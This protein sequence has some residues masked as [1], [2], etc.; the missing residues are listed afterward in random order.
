VQARRA[1]AFA[2]SAVV[3]IAFLPGLALGQAH[4]G[5]NKVHYQTFDWHVYRSPHFDVYY[6]P[7]G[8]PFLEQVVS[9]AESAYLYLS[10]ALD[11]EPK[12]R[13][14]LI[15]YRTHAEFEQTN[16]LLSSIPEGYLAFAEPLEH[17]VALSI[18]HPPD[19]V[20]KLIVHEL[21]HIFEFSILFQDSLGRAMRG[22]PPGWLME[23]LASYLAKD[24]N[25]I[26]QLVIRDA[27]IN[28][29]VPPIT[30]VT[31]VSFLTYRYGHAAFDF[32]ES[33]WG[34]EGLRTFIS[35]YRRVLLSSNI[36]KSIKEAFG[37][38]AEE[39][40]RLFKRYL[41]KKY[42]PTLLEKGEPE[43]Y[44]KEIGIK[45]P[46]VATVSPVLSPSG[47]LVAVLTNRYK[48]LD[49]VVLSTKDGEVIKNLTRGFTNSYEYVSS[50]AFR[51]MADLTWSPDGDRVAAFVRKENRRL[52]LIA[53]ALTGRKVALVEVNAANAASPAFSPDGRTILFSG[54][55]DGV[56]DIFELDLETGESRNITNDEYHDSNP[57]WSADGMTILYNRRVDAYAKIFLLDYEDPSRKTQV[58]F[59][60]TS[61]ITPSFSRDG[62]RI[63]YCSDAGEEGIFNIYSLDLDSG[64][65][66]KYT[67]VAGG[68]FQPQD[69]P[70]QEGKDTV[71]AT[72]FSKGR[73]RLFE[74]D[75]TKPLEVISP[76]ERA[77]QIADLEPFAAPLRLTV[78][79]QEKAPL[80]KRTY[81]IE[82]VPQVGVGVANDGTIYG[83]AFLLFSDLLGD[84]RFWV[85]ITSVANFQNFDIGYINLE[86]RLHYNFRIIDYRDFVLYG[87]ATGEYARVRANRITGGSAG[88]SYPL[89]KNYRVESSLGVYGREILDTGLETID[90]P[91]T[92][93]TAD[94]GFLTNSS[95]K[96]TVAI[97]SGSL[98]GDTV[99]Y[100]P[101]GPWHGKRF[102]FTASGA[103]FTSGD[104]EANFVNYSL[105][106]R[107]Y[108]KVTARSLF[109][110]RLSSFVSTGPG[111]RL[112]GIGGINQ[113]RGYEFREFIGD[114]AAWMNL[115]FR[116]PLVDELRLPF[117]SMRWF[118]GMVF[119]DV[120]AAWTQD[121]QFFDRELGDIGLIYAMG[122][123][124][125][126]RE[127][128]FW[129]T[130]E[131][132][133]QDGRA[134]YGLGFGVRLGIFDLT[135]AFAKK[136]KHLETAES[137]CRATVNDS[138]IPIDP[139]YPFGPCRVDTGLMAAALNSC[140]FKKVPTGGWS[141]TFYIG[142]QF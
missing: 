65:V 94:F 87:T 2:L 53:N 47:D 30:R 46:G 141:S 17:R 74:V 43:D 123:P 137:T 72:T 111:A 4:F 130:D 61:D 38:D 19:E 96:S 21:T 99:R 25:N 102:N 64:V 39:F 77:E 122:Q 120:G 3:V 114:R 52:L 35:E 106:Y 5:K 41:R 57:S 134:S 71:V 42:L 10:Q 45:L 24:E 98:V 9:Y 89:S 18:D 16:I 1:A 31:G 104:G 118:R 84:R 50:M 23:G 48:D 136:I 85:N 55:V 56:V 121:N 14:P 76:E 63:Y 82:T 79:E 8:E 139:S 100:N 138:C 128:K 103:P 110:F 132:M 119:M 129:N 58:T 80:K 28:G 108:G 109:A 97:L 26:D 125:V 117:G 101:W 67:D 68:F 49:V 62:K 12:F 70:A 81:H 51:G 133:L 92:P 20:Y 6:Y 135:W 105:D 32:I 40:D 127:F 36:E 78:D 93:D 37:I 91:N 115:E 112:F 69:R 140:E 73:F 15:Y 44:G 33:E 34:A 90:D 88:L 126:F 27:V 66:N 142:T 95:L 54:N 60:P 86:S 107:A 29:L 124:G 83:D 22:R 113:I 75:V 59:G 11:H 7:E 131:N 13:V 116:F